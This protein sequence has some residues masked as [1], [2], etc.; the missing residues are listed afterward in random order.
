MLKSIDWPSIDNKIEKIKFSIK[1]ID[2]PVLSNSDSL[3]KFDFKKSSSKLSESSAIKI[4]FKIFAILNEL[5]FSLVIQSISLLQQASI[6]LKKAKGQ[7]DR[8]TNLMEIRHPYLLEG[9]TNGGF[10]PSEEFTSTLRRRRE[11]AA[12]KK[13]H[14]T[15]R[16]KMLASRTNSMAK[17]GYNILYDL[18]G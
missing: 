11:R 18:L 7:K 2:S 13:H 14:Q 12:R 8:R 4:F 9:P 1:S 10:T 15:V 17:R 16:R 6:L 3:I 5:W